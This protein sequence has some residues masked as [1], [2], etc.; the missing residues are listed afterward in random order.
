MET[1]ICSH[2]GSENPRGPA[3]CAKCAESLST[4][5][6]KQT[7]AFVEGGQSMLPTLLAFGAAIAGGFGLLFLTRATMGVGLIGF[8]CLLAILGRLGQASGQD[9][10]MRAR[11]QALRTGRS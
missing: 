1:L 11:F 7:A 3:T 6:V 9:Q 5:T 2:C 10:R 4:A 8:G